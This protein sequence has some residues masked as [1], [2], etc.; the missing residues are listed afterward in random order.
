MNIEILTALKIELGEEL[1]QFA[2]SGHDDVND[3][4]HESADGDE[5]VIYYSKAE[6]LYNEASHEERQNAESNVSDCGGFGDDCDSMAQRFT[7]LAYW[8][9]RERLVEAVREQAE[10]AEEALREKMDDLEEISDVLSD[11]Y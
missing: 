1:Q 10:E 11:L 3:W 8:I 6:A 2:D 4:A 5:N 7:I 9:L